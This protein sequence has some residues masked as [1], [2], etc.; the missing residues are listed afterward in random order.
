MEMQ[1]RVVIISGGT[2]GIGKAIATRFVA[3]GARVA[4]LGLDDAQGKEVEDALRAIAKKHGAAECVYLHTD[5]SDAAQ[6]EQAIAAVLDRWHQIHVLV[7]NAAIMKTGTLVDMDEAD[8]DKT[9]AINLK[10]PFLLAK[11]AIAAMPP[12]GAIINISSVHAVATD[13]HSTAYTTSKGGLE[14]FTRALALECYPRKL[15]VNAMRLG[16]VDT[17]M[18]W[19]NPA[20]KSGDEKIVPNEVATPE[21]I[22][23]VALFLASQRSRFVSGTV[24]TVDGGRL[25]ILASHAD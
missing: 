10:G 16:A 18:L 6:V 21:Q 5:V 14:A 1:D 13:A 20:V 4:I 2:S 22:A 12:E 15:R 9:M 24:L 17:G 7:N 25:P 8:W 11:Y 19:E 23:E 3:E